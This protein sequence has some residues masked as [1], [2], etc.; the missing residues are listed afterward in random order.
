MRWR[1]GLPHGEEEFRQK[2]QQHA[3]RRRRR[4]RE[5]AQANSSHS[6]A[7]KPSDQMGTE[8]DGGMLKRANIE[9]KRIDRG[10]KSRAAGQGKAAEEN[11]QRLGGAAHASSL[12]SRRRPS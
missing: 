8:I 6:N 3:G 10:Q 11:Q 12:I 2:A 5:Q 4:Q 9:S 1:R 7:L